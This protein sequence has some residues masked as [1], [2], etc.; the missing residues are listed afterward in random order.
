MADDVYINIVNDTT[1]VSQ[2]TFNNLQKL[3]KQDIQNQ[4]EELKSEILSLTFPIGSKYTTQTKTNP[5]STLG[6]GTW[7]LSEGEVLVGIKDG[8]SDFSKFNQKGGTKTVSLSVANMAKHSH[9]LNNHTHTFSGT[10]SSNGNHSHSGVTRN[11]ALG[12]YEFNRPSGYDGQQTR[13]TTNES[14]NHVHNF[15][16]T[17][18]GNNGSTTEVGQGEAFKILQPYRVVGYVWIRT[19]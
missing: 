8:D 19:A 6:F 10:T 1:P 5:S 14:G 4:R 13:Q 9:G 11:G 12:A 15:S 7:E 2:T 17:T 16:G 3:I 18:S